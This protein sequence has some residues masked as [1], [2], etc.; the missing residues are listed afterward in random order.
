ML[1]FCKPVVVAW[2]VMCAW[3]SVSQILPHNFA[4]LQFQNLMSMQMDAEFN[5]E[6]IGTLFV[7]WGHWKGG[8][9]GGWSLRGHPKKYTCQKHPP[10]SPHKKSPVMGQVRF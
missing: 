8:F 4:T 5:K 3:A 9:G 2:Y 6:Q 10:G 7:W 1:G